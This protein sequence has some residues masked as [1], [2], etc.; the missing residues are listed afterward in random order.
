MYATSNIDFTTYSTSEIKTGQWIDGKNIYCKTINF[1]SLPSSNTGKRVAHNITNLAYVVNW[2]GMT[3]YS[4]D[5]VIRPLPFVSPSG[6]NQVNV[7]FDKTDVI[8][9]AN[10]DRSNF[11]AYITMYYTKTS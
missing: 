10:S 11:S 3:T 1:G 6:G 4:N 2:F 5:N 8:I 7:E 9:Y